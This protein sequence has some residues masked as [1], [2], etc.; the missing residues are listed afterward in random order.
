MQVLL[1]V[2][3]CGGISYCASVVACCCLWWNNLLRKC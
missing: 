2:A 1:R 3:V